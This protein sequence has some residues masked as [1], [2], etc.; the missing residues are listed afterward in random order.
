MSS[1]SA[2]VTVRLVRSFEYKTVRV[3]YFHELSLDSTTLQQLKESVEER[4]TP[5]ISHNLFILW[6]GVKTTENLKF[7]QAVPFDTFK[8]YS[9]P[10]GAKTSNPV[11]NLNNDETL[12]LPD[13]SQTLSA[14]GFRTGNQMQLIY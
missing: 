6:L 8:I 1:S 10:H 11:I 2:T 9:Q 4:T 7:L 12:I 5:Q 3:L 14:L 13:W